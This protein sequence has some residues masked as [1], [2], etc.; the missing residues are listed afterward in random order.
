MKI[1]QNMPNWI[2]LKFTKL[3]LTKMW[4]FVTTINFESAGQCW[5]PGSNRAKKHSKQSCNDGKKI[6]LKVDANAIVEEV[7]PIVIV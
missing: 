4:W 1:S 3:H 5:P 2:I 7:R 6:K